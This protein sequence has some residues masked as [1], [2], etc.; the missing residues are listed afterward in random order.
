MLK[1]KQKKQKQKQQ[2]KKK[3]KKKKKKQNEMYCEKQSK[4]AKKEAMSGIWHSP[5]P[6]SKTYTIAAEN[7]YQHAEHYFRSMRPEPDGT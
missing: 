5:V 3:K 6:K 7:D 1:T 4:R 2:Q